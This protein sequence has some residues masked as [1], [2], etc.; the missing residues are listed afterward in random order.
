M[1]AMSVLA[2]TEDAEQAAKSWMEKKY[3]KKL[4]KVKFVEVMVEGGVWTLKAQVKLA[5]GVLLVKPHVVQLKIDSASMNVLG[6]STAE[7]E[8]K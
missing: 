6:Y 3:G 7:V 8:P 1:G 2:T 5:T 4:G